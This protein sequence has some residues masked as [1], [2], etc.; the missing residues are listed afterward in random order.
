MT[1]QPASRSPW[2]KNT[3]GEWYVVVQTVL[4]ALVAF[5]PLS[6]PAL[7]PDVSD[8]VRAA[9]MIAGIGLG[10]A[11]LLL[12]LAGL[13]GLGSNLSVFPHPKDDATLVQSGAYGIVRHPIYSGLIIGAAGWALLTLS[14]V[15]LAYALVLFVF[16]DV[17]SR[18]EERMLARKFPAYADYQQRVRKLIPYIY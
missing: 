3:R 4:F 6:F 13:F 15:T 8:T 18:R 5:G 9:A 10:G 12:A 7:R 11:G 2:W 1:S 16:F 14:I 17:K